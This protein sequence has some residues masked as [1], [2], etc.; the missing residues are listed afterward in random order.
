MMAALCVIGAGG[1]VLF[2]NPIT[3][4]LPLLLAVFA[5]AAI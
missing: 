3:N 4:E 1:V 2:R 5:L